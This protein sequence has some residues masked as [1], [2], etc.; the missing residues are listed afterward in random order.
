MIYRHRNNPPMHTAYTINYRHKITEADVASCT[1]AD[2]DGLS[3]TMFCTG[4]QFIDD[5]AQGSSVILDIFFLSFFHDLG[6][7]IAMATQSNET[8]ERIMSSRGV[9]FLSFEMSISGLLTYF[10]REIKLEE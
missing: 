5:Y 4:M 9:F 8:E 1:Q 6:I 3:Y 7:D 10:T 2:E